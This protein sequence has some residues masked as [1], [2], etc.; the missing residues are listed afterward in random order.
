MTSLLY[1][2]A[3]TGFFC[4]ALVTAHAVLAAIFGEE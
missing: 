1:L 2:L 3:Y 4:I